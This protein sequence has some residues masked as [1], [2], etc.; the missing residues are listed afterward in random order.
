MQSLNA[1]G[2]PVD[3]FT[4]H[5]AFSISWGRYTASTMCLNCSGAATRDGYRIDETGHGSEGAMSVPCSILIVCDR[6]PLAKE[7]RDA[8]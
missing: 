6:K 3:A 7:K 4:A 8:E 2:V 1:N 5:L